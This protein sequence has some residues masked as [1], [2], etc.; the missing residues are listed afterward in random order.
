MDVLLTW[1]GSRDPLWVNPRTGEREPGPILSLLK[2]RPF[3]AVYLLLNFSRVEDFPRRA[4]AVLRACELHFPSMKMKQKPV[5]LISVTDYRE[6]FRVTNHVCQK[7][8][9]E[10]GREGREYWVYLSPGTPQM[11][12]VWVLL[13]QSGLLP[14]RMIQTTP[15]DLL[16]PGAP[17]WRQVD[18]SLPDFPQVVNAG[19]T[20]RLVGV[21]QAQNENLQAANRRLEADL[22][23]LRAGA[24]APMDQEIPAGFRL[25]DYL[26]AQERALYV[27][28]LEQSHGNAADA[29]RLLGVEPAALRARAATLGVR[30]R[31]RR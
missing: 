6:I 27:R 19:E 14:A 9:E 31:R 18:L 11:Q 25:R 28:A 21:L 10:E 5:E 29:A 7:I 16:A 30:P 24:M 23:S 12:T 15:P 22:G 2:V 20:P 13:V 3:D 26:L 4:T 17:P 1:V 8:L